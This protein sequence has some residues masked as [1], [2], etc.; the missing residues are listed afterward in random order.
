MSFSEMGCISLS[1]AVSNLF[2]F[3]QALLIFVFFNKLTNLKT[4]A[5]ILIFLEKWN[6]LGSMVPRCNFSSGILSL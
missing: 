6:L 5:T 1:V 4:N 3:L 2:D